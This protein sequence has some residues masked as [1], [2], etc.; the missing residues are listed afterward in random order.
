MLKVLSRCH[1]VILFLASPHLFPVHL[2]HSQ[3][4]KHR[5]FLCFMSLRLPM[6]LTLH[7]LFPV[8]QTLSLHICPELASHFRSLLCDPSPS[9]LNSNPSR[10][11]FLLCFIF[12]PNTSHVLNLCI[13]LIFV[14][15]S[16]FTNV[17]KPRSFW[18]RVSIQAIFVERIN[19]NSVTLEINDVFTQLIP[20][21]IIHYWELD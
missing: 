20:R 10:A 4:P 5:D 7:F 14:L 6:P 21:L 1:R 11:M 12:L 8:F 2:S 3:S 19:A 15:F 17:Q 9:T 18:S 13:C 16:L